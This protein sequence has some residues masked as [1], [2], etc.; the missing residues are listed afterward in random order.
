M[1]A[2]Q[3]NV[4][5]IY[6]IEVLDLWYFEIFVFVTDYVILNFA[7]ISYLMWFCLWRN[8]N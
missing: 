3:H 4:C 2:S 5:K 1:T 6:I 7:I 8:T